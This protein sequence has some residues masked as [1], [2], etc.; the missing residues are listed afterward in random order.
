MA[1][2]AGSGFGGA[3]MTG[4]SGRNRRRRRLAAGDGRNNGPVHSNILTR[5]ARL[6]EMKLDVE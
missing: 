5:T 6:L 4:D 3:K 2:G 1:V